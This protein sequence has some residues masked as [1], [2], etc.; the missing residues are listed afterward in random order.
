[1]LVTNEIITRWSATLSTLS[2][3]VGDEKVCRI[4]KNICTDMDGILKEPLT[5]VVKPIEYKLQ[6]QTPEPEVAIDKSDAPSAL[7]LSRNGKVVWSDDEL[8]IIRCASNMMQA[9]EYYHLSDYNGKHSDKAIEQAY[10]RAKANRELIRVNDKVRIVLEGN[11]HQGRVAKVCKICD[12]K[13]SA[14]LDFE[15]NRMQV[16]IAG[17][18]EMS[19]E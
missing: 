15:G 5:Q 4:L 8:S 12:D 1:M 3:F 6:V 9:K 7:K 19:H 17:L 14:I 16:K 10:Y 11:M 18:E 2:E 13:M